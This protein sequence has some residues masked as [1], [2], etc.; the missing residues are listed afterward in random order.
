MAPG[1]RQVLPEV[2]WRM[3]RVKPELSQGE[4]CCG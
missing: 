4:E 3:I 2:T 1:I